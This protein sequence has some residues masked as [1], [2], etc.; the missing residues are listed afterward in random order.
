MPPRPSPALL[1]GFGLA[2]TLAS[3][4]AAATDGA[5][6]NPIAIVGKA[7]GNTIVSTYPDGRKAQLW[8]KADGSYTGRGRYGE[9]CSGKW[10]IRG[11]KL[12]LRQSTPFPAPIRFCTPIPQDALRTSW[13]AKAVTG[14]M[15][16]VDLVQG[17]TPDGG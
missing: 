7:F 9:A 1:A 15:I 12:C 14:E 3:A 2:A 11:H 13:T 4:A 16:R 8:L 5:G 10:N 17:G 6:F